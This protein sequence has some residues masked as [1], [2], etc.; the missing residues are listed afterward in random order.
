[1]FQRTP[2]GLE[3]NRRNFMFLTGAGAA[4]T[5]LASCGVG[6]GTTEG[7]DRALKA[8]F[9]Q[10]IT[11]LDP[12]AANTAVDEASLIAKYLIFDTLVRRN[13][14]EI[15]PSLATEWKQADPTTWVFT[16]R[17][18]VSF[19]DGT[20]LTAED[21]VQ[22]LKRIQSVTSAQ[23]PLWAP[24][25]SAEA[26][27]TSTVTFKTDGPLGTLPVNLTLLFIVPAASANS[28]D[29]FAN[30]VGSGPYT[31]ASFVPSSSLKLKR[32]DQYWG[33]AGKVTDIEMPYIAETSSAIT[34]LSTGEVDLLW[35]VP[36]DQVKEVEAI[37][38]ATVERIPS[39]VYYFNW[40]NCSR[41]P[42][43]D[44]NV[45]R[46][47]WHALDVETIVSTLYGEGAEVM[48]APIPSTVFGYAKQ[49]PYRHD[50]D[51]ARKLLKEA[52]MADG[53]ST[54]LMWFA[55]TGPS[56]TE[57]AQAMISDWAK[58]GVKVEAQ[59]IEKA[60]WLQR[61]NTLDWDMDLQTNTVTTGDADF[62]LGRLYT[63]AANRLGYSNQEL[64]AV[65]DKAHSIAE[66]PEREK[67]Y[68]EACKTIWDEAAG[69]FP[70][71]IVTTYGRRK[72]LEGFVPVAS[73]QPDLSRIS[74]NAK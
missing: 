53:F 10:P 36:A 43:T 51:L 25:L 41:P 26:T 40:F 21:V 68:A 48:T 74:L 3:I 30:P 64:D 37:G 66:Q 61:L 47:M 31:V 72:S 23:T 49:E 42:F 50:P 44:A 62:T 17:D 58:I 18:D 11:D 28:P 60:D 22:S 73:N 16:L 32:S 29:F 39:Y 56:A 52:G 57:L 46:A 55:G 9:S 12:H 6:G 69:I 7:A 13:G 14:T 34:S 27:G 54:S 67:L 35:P 20:P 45:R 4:A 24:V 33:D 65:L 5:F 59:S 63:S 38:D 8:V 2:G 70:A 71:S 1:M 19:H 15:V